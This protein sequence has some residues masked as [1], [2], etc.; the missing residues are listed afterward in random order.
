MESK[1]MNSENEILRETRRR[2]TK[3]EQEDIKNKINSFLDSGITFS[4][5]IAKSV[6]GNSSKH[7]L[8]KYIGSLVAYFFLFY[9]L[10]LFLLLNRKKLRILENMR[11]NRRKKKIFIFV[12]KDF[13]T[14]ILNVFQ[15]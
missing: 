12:K 11:K 3:G 7:G 6:R 15:C 5:Q 4:V 13:L 14:Y 2:L 10:N 9:F 8:T 1:K